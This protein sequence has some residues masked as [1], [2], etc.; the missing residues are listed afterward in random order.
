VEDALGRPHPEPALSVLD[1]RV[2]VVGEEAVARGEGAE[3]AALETIEALPRADPQRVVGVD[4]QGVDARAGQAVLH[5]V[6]REAAV[7]E[8]IEAAP[9]RGD[10]EVARV[11]L[12]Q[13]ADGIAAQP[14]LRR[15]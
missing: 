3:A 7:L 2:D 12:G 9:A 10:P 6:A 4:V 13:G 11:V 5:S 1:E 8:S 14:L 15:V